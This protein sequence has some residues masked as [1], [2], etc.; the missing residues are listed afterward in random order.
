MDT[1]CCDERMG[2]GIL[3]CVHAEPVE[4]I[5][6]GC[7]CTHGVES[8]AAPHVALREGCEV[9]PGYETEVVAAATKRKVQAGVGGWGGVD[10]CAV[11][12]DDLETDNLVRERCGGIQ[13]RTN[14]VVFDVVAGP[15]TEA[16]EE[17][18]ST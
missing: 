14:F 2:L 18:Y 6:H 17:G 13:G 5:D 12:E 15:A 10:D 4:G 16:G 1:G 3:C 11:G 7:V 9:H 8:F